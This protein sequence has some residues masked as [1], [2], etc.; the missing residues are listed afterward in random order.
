MGARH[1]LHIQQ[2]TLRADLSAVCSI[3]PREQAWAREKLEPHGTTIYTSY[4]DLLA[5]P[6]LDAVLVATSTSVHAE[7][8]VKAIKSGKHV[9]CEKPLSTKLVEVCPWPGGMEVRGKM[10]GGRMSRV[11]VDNGWV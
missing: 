1:A 2:R 8:A 9:L 4:D 11:W 6:G 3:E 7:F 10:Y 5:H